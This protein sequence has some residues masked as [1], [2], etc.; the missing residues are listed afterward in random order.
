MEFKQFTHMKKIVFS[1]LALTLLV[2]CNPHDDENQVLS[3]FTSIATVDNPTQTSGFYFKLDNNDKMWITSTYFPYYSPKT[4]QRIIANYSI[5]SVNNDGSTYNHKVQLNDFYEVLTKGIFN[6]TPA[7]QDSIGNDQISIDDIWIGSDYLNVEFTYPGYNKIHYINLVADTAKK[8]TDNKIHLEFR[9]NANS[10]Y[11][12]YS[13]WG[14]V[15]FK[16]KSLQANTTADSV[17]LVIHSKEFGTPTDKT[18][19]LTYKF[20]QLGNS[21]VKKML[22]PTNNEKIQ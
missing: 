5:L 8:Y 9:H 19:N 3:D 16:L 1:M 17:N 15:S 22:F 11:A 20:G 2:A 10:D 12:T 7:T 4:G 13:K 6:I 18:Y 21:N 14:I